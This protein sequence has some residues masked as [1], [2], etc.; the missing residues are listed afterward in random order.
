MAKA[1]FLDRDGVVN[2]DKEYVYKKEDFEFM[3]GIFELCKFY[4]QNGYL[5]FI[6][7]NQAGIGRGFYSEK[8]FLLLTQWMKEQ[9]AQNDVKIS[10]VRY[11]PHHPEHGVGQYKIDCECRKPKSGMILK[12]A[13]DYDIDLETSVL[14]G[15]KTSD[16]EAGKS[17]KIKNNILIK[18]EYQ[19][20]FDFENLKKL[21]EN[22]KGVNI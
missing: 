9:F 4:S 15:D 17:S 1:L 14:V 20:E 21:L 5:I 22:L 3:D 16:I 12:I 8:D 2:I 19:K 7:T 11:C 13:K 10:D 6:I 18:S